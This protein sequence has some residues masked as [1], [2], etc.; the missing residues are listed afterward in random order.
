MLCPATTACLFA[1]RILPKISRSLFSSAGSSQMKV[2]VGASQFSVDKSEREIEKEMIG[3]FHRF[4]CLLSRVSMS[5]AISGQL[6]SAMLWRKFSFSE[7]MARN[8]FRWS[9]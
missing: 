7:V 6:I 1:S 5:K 8:L 3:S 2:A 9:V 4:S